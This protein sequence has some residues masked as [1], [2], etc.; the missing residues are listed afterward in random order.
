MLD[1][2]I[3][4]SYSGQQSTSYLHYEKILKASVKREGALENPR[5]QCWLLSLE[6]LKE[7]LKAKLFSKLFKY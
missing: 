7:E 6:E 4:T 2:I 3:S 1:F 5:Y